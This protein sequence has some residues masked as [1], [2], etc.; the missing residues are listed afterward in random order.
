MV[1]LFPTKV[2]RFP[3][4]LEQ[5]MKIADLSGEREEAFTAAVLLHQ[6]FISA[7]ADSVVR[8]AS[9]KPPRARSAKGREPQSSLF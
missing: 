5:E 4:D 1:V 7:A 6:Q 2:Q 9:G 3:K 8:F